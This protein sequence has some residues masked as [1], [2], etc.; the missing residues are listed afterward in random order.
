MSLEIQKGLLQIAKG[1]EFLHESAKMVHGNLTPE[2]VFVNAKSDWKIS[3]LA[4]MGPPGNAEGHQS[5]PTLALSEVLH[6]DPRLPRSVQINLDYTS[7]DFVLDNNVNVLA[8]IFSLGL[9]TV[10]LYNL[11]HASPLQTSGN[12]STYKSIFANSKAPMSS[13]DYLSSRPLPR[14]VSQTLPKML[15]RRPAQRISAREFQQSPYFDNILVNTIKF[16]DELPAKT[17]H[18]KA[19]FM[20]GL[21]RVMPQFPPSVLGNKVLSA[22]LEETKDKELLSLILQNVFK[23]I[24]GIPTAR[25]VFPEKVLPRLKEVFLAKSKAEE[26]DTA[27]EAGLVV[28]LENMQ[29]MIDNCSA[30]HFKDDVMPIVHLAMESSTHSLV[31]TSFQ[32]LGTILPVLDFTT[33]KHDLFPVVANVFSKTSSLSIKVRGL[34]ALNVLCGGKINAKPSDDDFDGSISGPQKITA[35]AV[36]TA[37]DKFT[38]QEKVVPLLKGIKTKEPSVMMAALE[39]FKQVGQIADTDFLATD[40]VPI[41]WAFALGPLLNLEQFKAFMDVVKLISAKIEK[42]QIRK[43]QELSAS[44]GSRGTES[45]DRNLSNG[46]NGNSAFT[47]GTNSTEDFER[48]VLGA[49]KDRNDL[50]SSVALSST[51]LSQEQQRPQQQSHQ[52]S[53]SSSTAN[54]ANRPSSTYSNTLQPPQPTSRSITPDINMSPFPALQPQ[55]TT[56]MTS[57]RPMQAAISPSANPLATAPPSSLNRSTLPTRDTGLQNKN[58]MQPSNA[59]STAPPPQQVPHSNPW[60]SPTRIPANINTTT[61]NASISRIAP[62]PSIGNVWAQQAQQSQQQQPKPNS[63][64]GLDKYQSLL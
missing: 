40:V 10:A 24:G 37:L 3:G 19:Q 64:S 17:S 7:P 38:V 51:T 49:R 63:S 13:N 9:L 33:I 50:F 21:G 36:S 54:T 58:Y 5:M 23:I 18:E 11:P 25:N 62:P 55:S 59:F 42:E 53:W 8:D 45:S 6:H 41:L 2:A 28:F 60:A 56:A 44:N 57:T 12:Q 34:E 48:L 22:L 35:P 32:T 15:A 43:L 46:R 52:F 30:K 20:R 29:L 27:K 14:Q 61:S 4:F 1:L 31:D 26:R 39:V 16:L 47:V